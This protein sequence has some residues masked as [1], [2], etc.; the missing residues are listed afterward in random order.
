M[1]PKS[2]FGHKSR[3][4]AKNI[5]WALNRTIRISPPRTVV[6]S[7]S[8]RFGTRCGGQSRNLS[9]V[10]LIVG[11]KS[12]GPQAWT[13]APLTGEICAHKKDGRTAE[14]F[15]CISVCGIQNVHS[16]SNPRRAKRLSISGCPAGRVAVAGVY[17]SDSWRGKRDPA[18]AMQAT[19]QNQK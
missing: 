15:F 17:T 1:A 8:V 11:K 7:F 10:L 19:A 6:A 9:G 16:G 13:I 12:C 18:S 5:A 3:W 14:K 4:W 2:G